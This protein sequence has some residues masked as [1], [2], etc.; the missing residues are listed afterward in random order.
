M[1]AN[2]KLDIRLANKV[3]YELSNLPS[4]L[5]CQLTL[6]SKSKAESKI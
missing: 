1:S 2:I 4:R 5:E 6:R 3:K